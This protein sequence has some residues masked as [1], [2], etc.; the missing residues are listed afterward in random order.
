[1]KKI[2]TILFLSSSLL[3]FGQAP[4]IEA[5]YLPVRGTSIKEVWD[6]VPNT[7]TVPDTGINKVWNYSN[8]FINGI[9]TFTIK[10]F[11]PDTIVNGLAFGQYFPTATHASYLRSPL[12]NLTDSL[13]SYYI[14]DADGLHM[15]GGF[16]IR[17]QTAN[18]V[19]YDT[20][21][22]ITPSELMTPALVTYGM[23]RNDTSR[24]VTYGKYN[25]IPIKIR[26]TKTKV[27][28]GV[29]Y[30]TLT[31]PNG[32]IFN[33]V[34]LAKQTIHTVDSVFA[35][36]SN[37]FMTVLVSDY[38][39]YSFLR[40]NTFGSSY[41]MYLNA[42][43]GNTLINYGWYTLPVDFGSISGTVYESAGS[44]TPTTNGEALL[45]REN[46][47]FAKNDILDRSI[48]DGSG[49]Y[50][51]DSIPY[52]EYRVAIRADSAS[53]LNVFTTYYGDTS[54]W[55]D[56]TPII[57]TANSTGNDI[58]LQYHP[59]PDPNGGEIQGNIGLDL[60]IRIND[61]IPGVDI[62]VK[63]NPGGIAVQEVTTDANG[64][65]KLQQLPP[66]V[67]PFTNYDLFVDIPGL[68]MS[69]TYD[70]IV[71]SGTV[72][73]SLDFTVGTDSIHPNS[74]FV[75]IKEHYKNDNL[76][77]A[78]PNPYSSNTV[79]KVN[80]SEKSDVLLEVYNLLG[81]KIKTLDNTQKLAGLHYY[82]FNA[83]SLNF[84]AGVYIVKLSAGS[85][86]SVLKIIE[87]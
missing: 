12:N 67:A 63:K 39:D 50:Q 3:S 37:T 27:M 18:H 1:M 64:D 32:A 69:G 23:V 54:N 11:H 55:L 15:L 62:I 41:L 70:I 16:N 29:G 5:T 66:L 76:L 2:A 8:E 47:N 80:L 75:G 82:N 86:T 10:T 74:E 35:A 9:D 85:K 24:Y 44:T 21:A 42:N 34:L 14:I 53:H 49:N 48:L 65:F 26:G 19:G 79:I 77:G 52:G 46:S 13:Y 33:D 78:Y 28:A 45:Y 71:I 68:H 61:P 87:Q 60:D 57:T 84:P 38:M 56:A 36:G 17:A 83:K 4:I 25:N 22:I 73:N 59:A 72:I 30:G 40:N 31:M 6:I 58:Y 20:T 43:S 51:F 7:I 81:E